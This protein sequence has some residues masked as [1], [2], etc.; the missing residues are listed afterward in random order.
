MEFPKTYSPSEFESSLAEM[1]EKKGLYAPQKSRTGKT[2]YIPLPPPNVTG[3]LHTGHALM[4]SVQDVMVR[5]HRMK[6]DETLW[7]PGT[8]HAGISTQN[9][10]TKNLSKEGI[11]KDELGREKFLE[12]VWE[13]KEACHGT[14]A[15][16]MRMM[17]ASVSWDH[18]RFTLDEG[19]N[20]LV[21]DTFIKLYEEG[22]IYR[23]EYMVNYCPKDKTVIS[24]SE[25]EY[26]EEE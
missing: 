24:K 7:V 17:G 6:G 19:N 5:Y 1:W 22:I 15:G 4:L 26:R 21:T 14:I 16:Q 20:K 12:K 10:V 23:G 11:R 25:I 13:W 2:F 9:V 18:E 3:V 8:D